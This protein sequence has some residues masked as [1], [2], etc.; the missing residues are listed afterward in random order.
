MIRIDSERCI[1]CGRCVR[2]CF[3]GAIGLEQQKAVLML[4]ENCIGCGHCIALCPVSAV[5]DDALPMDDVVSCVEKAEPAPLLQL[6]RSRR[7]CRHYQDRAVPDDL[8]QMLL[9][10]A[11]ACPTAK[12]LQA[13]RY[14]IVTERIPELLDSALS[15][16]GEI[17][18]KQKDSASDP[19]EIRRAENFIRWADQRKLDPGFDPLFFHAPL[20][21]LFVSDA[22]TAMDAA[23]AAAY[24]ELMA[25]SL[26]LGCLYSGYFTACAAMSQDIK[27]KLGLKPMEQVSRS[28]V[29]GWPDVHFLRTAPRKPVDITKL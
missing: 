7:S 18:A 27:D 2:D 29:L 15:T 10:A 3:P 14:I 13:T 24:T 1:G 20:L 28:L 17:G 25:A 22:E 6:M 16:L 9:Q 19:S 23:G 26:G 11:R 8:I 4:P 12:N 21:L 5:T